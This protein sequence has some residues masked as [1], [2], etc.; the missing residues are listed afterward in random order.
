MTDLKRETTPR[1]VSH[2][3]PPH[4]PGG[5]DYNQERS[6]FLAD[7]NQFQSGPPLLTR[8]PASPLSTYLS[9]ISS[10]GSQREAPRQPHGEVRCCGDRGTGGST[11]PIPT[12]GKC[13][14]DEASVPWAL[15]SRCHLLL[16]LFVVRCCL[17]SC[18]F[19]LAGVPSLVSSHVHSWQSCQ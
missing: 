4:L 2:I 12:T 13:L 19:Q 6:D 17:V 7:A 11:S 14:R 10:L 16:T 8:S 1:L 9:P 5:V 18:P 15:Q 3:L